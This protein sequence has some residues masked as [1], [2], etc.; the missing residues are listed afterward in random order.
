MYRNFAIEPFLT[1]KADP[2]P[3]VTVSA[4]NVWAHHAASNDRQAV[5]TLNDILRTE[6]EDTVVRIEA[7]RGLVVTGTPFLHINFF[8]I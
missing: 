5:S 3:S 7:L 2:N 8:C 4:L 1:M 6:K